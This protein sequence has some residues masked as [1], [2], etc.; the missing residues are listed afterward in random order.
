VKPKL[1]AALVVG[2]PAVVLA[3]A[4]MLPASAETAAVKVSTIQYHSPGKDNRSN[5]SLNGEYVAVTNTGT[6]AANLDRWTLRDAAGHI[7]TFPR[8]L[9]QPAGTV[10]VH[11][12]RGSNGRPSSGH[13]YWRS[14]TYIWDDDGDTATL[15]NASG[16]TTATCAWTGAGTGVTSCGSVAAPSPPTVTPDES[17]PPPTITESTTVTPPPPPVTSPAA[18]TPPTLP[19]DPTDTAD[20]VATPP[21]PLP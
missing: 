10:Y 11:T 17:T 16:Q 9:L 8:Y 21:P 3:G 2:L 7:F 14:G 6:A 1:I 4:V 19:P 15:T 13:L 12:G 18:T 5:V 20:G